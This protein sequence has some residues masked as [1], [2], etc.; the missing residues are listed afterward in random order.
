MPT[1]CATA[2]RSSGTWTTPAVFDEV[3]RFA[4]L[5]QEVRAHLRQLAK[6]QHLYQRQGW[7]LDAAA[8]YCDA[9]QSLVGHLASAQLGS[10]ALLAFREYLASYVASAGF[11]ALVSDTRSRKAALS[12][13]RYCTR[14]R[15]H[16]VEVSRYQEEAD[17]SATVLQ[18]FERFKQGAVTT[19]GSATGRGRGS[20][21]SPPRSSTWWRGCSRRSS[22]PWT[23]YCQQHA[24]FV[25]EGIRRA[26]EELQ[27]YLAYVDHIRPLRAAGLRFCYPE[28]SADSKEVR[29]RRYLRP[30]SGAQAR[31]RARAGG[32]QR[33]PPGRS[34]ADLRRDRT[35]PGREDHLRADLRPAPPPGQRRLPGSGQ[36]R[37]AVPVRSLF[38]HF[39]QGGG[40]H[41][42]DREA[43]GRPGAGSGRSCGRPPRPAS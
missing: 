1:P 4:G 25:D 13:I 23:E 14:I 8:I 40:P 43:G 32:H 18:T 26:D 15:G 20:T 41:H 37:P 30:G 3:Q 21:T 11:T 31:R 7:L 17:Y 10:R 16:R 36:R 29:R 33:L 2:R 28:V 5:M 27:F 35:E 22:P 39:A 12:Q 42:D 24:G 19:T 38:T 9:V 6:M 34:R